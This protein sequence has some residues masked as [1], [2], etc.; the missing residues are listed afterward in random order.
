[1]GHTDCAGMH[2]DEGIHSG[3]RVILDKRGRQG[4]R[5]PEKGRREDIQDV[6][7][8][9]HVVVVV[10]VA[11]VKSRSSFFTRGGYQSGAVL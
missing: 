7:G 6:S 2:G 8:A 5:C 10:V 4:V 3:A 9:Q 1:M 11:L